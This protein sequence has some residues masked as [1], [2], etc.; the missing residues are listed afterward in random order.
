MTM[1]LCFNYMLYRYLSFT[2]HFYTIPIC[3]AK[4]FRLFQLSSIIYLTLQMKPSS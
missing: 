4:K 3:F 1:I 2:K